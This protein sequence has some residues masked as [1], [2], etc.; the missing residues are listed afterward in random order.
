[1]SK[2]TKVSEELIERIKVSENFSAIPYKKSYDVWT[3]GYGTTRYFDTG[4]K[5]TKNDKVIN[6]AEGDR[7]LRGWFTKKVEP[8]VDKVLRD[9]I[10]SYDFD[11]VADFIY[12]AGATYI[13]KRGKIQYFNLFD[14]I[15]RK[16]PRSELEPYWEN[17]CITASGIKLNGL[18]KRRKEEVDNYYKKIDKDGK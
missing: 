18:I 12:N 15:N 5:V 17:L 11:A 4:K 14:K 8:L 9:D 7:L 2:I 10:D 16:V 3:I 1:M 13:D 6:K